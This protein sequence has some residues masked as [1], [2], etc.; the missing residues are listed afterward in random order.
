MDFATWGDK[1]GPRT[2]FGG[3]S[4]IIPGGCLRSV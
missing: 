3:V 4:G 1:D 2:M